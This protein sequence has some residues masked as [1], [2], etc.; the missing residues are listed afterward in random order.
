MN[1]E[2]E[3]AG[4]TFIQKVYLYLSH[5]LPKKIKSF[6][7]KDQIAAYVVRKQVGSCGVNLVVNGCFRGF[8]RHVH[9]GDHVNFNDNVFLNGGGE[10]KIGS[11]FH[12]GVNL[13]IISTNHN[14]DDAECIPYDK[15][16][17]HKPVCI[18]DFVWCGNNVTI[19]PGVT[20]GEGA[21]IA[22]GS[23]VTRNVP[24]YAIVGGN[25]ASLIK[26]R[27]IKRFLDLKRSGKFLGLDQ[28]KKTYD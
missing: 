27:N 14:Y 16:R 1:S 15:V 23:V 3:S 7:R 28:S 9:L 19:I 8:G 21:I 13:T 24:D 18:G 10:V 4:L 5:S 20:I 6:V 12:S 25:P 22:A 11:H 2:I 26:Y 17:I